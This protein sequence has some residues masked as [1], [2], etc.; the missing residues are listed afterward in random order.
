MKHPDRSRAHLNLPANDEWIRFHALVLEL[1]RAKD[2]ETLSHAL[3]Q[4]LKQLFGL[5]CGVAIGR[6]EPSGT[7]AV[8]SSEIH[9]DGFVLHPPHPL[10]ET[11]QHLLRCLLDHLR[12]AVSRIRGHRPQ[13]SPPPESPILSPRQQEVL[14]RLLRGC[15]NS[16]IAYEL[17]ISVRTVEKHV[18]AILRAHGVAGRVRLLAVRQR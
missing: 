9:V 16:E 18:T 12:I 10:D 15:S 1:H 5:P 8:D 7:T 3:T 6:W 11:R 17:G 14:E 4:G 2:A 13:T